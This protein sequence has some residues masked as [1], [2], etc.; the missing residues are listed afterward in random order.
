MVF[1]VHSERV[2]DMKLV[3]DCIKCQKKMPKCIEIN[4]NLDPEQWKVGGKVGNCIQLSEVFV[5]EG[6]STVGQVSSL[7]Q[8][9]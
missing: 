4:L 9:C 6:V 1:K 7:D 5:R 2:F 3:G 8:L